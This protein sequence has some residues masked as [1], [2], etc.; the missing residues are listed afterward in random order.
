MSLA[1]SNIFSQ[2][3]EIQKDVHPCSEK[4]DGSHL[5]ALASTHDEDH[6]YCLQSTEEYNDIVVGG[7]EV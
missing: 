3:N 4:K 1:T 2:G 5:S 6:K 7:P